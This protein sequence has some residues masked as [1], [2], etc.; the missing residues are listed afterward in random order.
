YSIRVGFAP[1]DGELLYPASTRQL[2]SLWA[3]DAAAQTGGSALARGTDASPFPGWQP[4]DRTYHGQSFTTQQVARW[5]CWYV[6]SV[7]GRVRP[8]DHTTAPPWPA[9]PA[10]SSSAA[11]WTSGTSRST[12]ASTTAT[13][14]PLSSRTWPRSSAQ[15]APADRQRSLAEVRR[16]GGA[17]VQADD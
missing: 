7:A 3:F 16:G 10:A 12:S 14:G 6:D 4:G 2:N 13:L 17:G 15:A 5:Y 1:D 9:R 11:G 8:R